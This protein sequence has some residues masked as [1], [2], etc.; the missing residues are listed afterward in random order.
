MTSLVRW[1]PF[2]D[3]ISLR[4]A[5]DRLFEESFVRPRTGWLAPLGAETLAVDMY[6]TDDA[7]VVKTAIPGVK[8]E[9]VDVSIAGDT[10]TI[11]GETKAEEEVKEEN[12]IRRE[13]RYG[14]FCRSLTLPVPVVADDAEAEFENGILTLTLP[15]AEE[16]RPKTIK[17]KAKGK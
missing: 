8:P 16:V 1:E 9:D 2:R 10:L 4:E 17:V 7:I 5:M 3:L 15:K 13:R 11:K 12:Y 14:S 6:E